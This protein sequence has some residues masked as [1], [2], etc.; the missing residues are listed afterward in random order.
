MNA[1]AI[2]ICPD[3]PRADFVDVLGY[4]E[5]IADCT[6]SGDRAPACT[7][8]RDH[9]GVQFWI[10]AK[11]DRGEYES[12]IAS[13]TDIVRAVRSIYFEGDS[14]FSDVSAAALYLIWE[15]ARNAE[16]DGGLDR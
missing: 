11:N 7:Y 12:R 4:I 3:E 5:E 16:A 8:V 14:D 13:D 6:A 10:I 2:E 1:L 15:A 9:I